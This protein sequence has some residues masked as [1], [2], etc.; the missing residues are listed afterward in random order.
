M[1]THR[2]TTPEDPELEKLGEELVKWATE[3]SKELR[4]QLKQWW[5]LEKGLL[6]KQWDLMCEKPV[7]QAYY[8]RA[9]T[10][11]STRYVDGSINAPIAN[12]FLRLYFPEIRKEEDEKAKYLANLNKEDTGLS[13]SDMVA[14]L[15]EN[16]F[17]DKVDDKDKS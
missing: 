17:L 2:T 3:E 5:C 8:E 10:A 16:G 6:K 7:F 13:M 1:G 9:Q 12:R 4:F 11:L 15:R 14:L